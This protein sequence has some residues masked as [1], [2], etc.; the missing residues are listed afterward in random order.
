MVVLHHQFNGDCF[1][2]RKLPEI[3]KDREAWFASVHEVANSRTTTY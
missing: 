3:V 1:S 2:R